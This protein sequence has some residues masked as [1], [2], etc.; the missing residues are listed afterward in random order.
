MP[1]AC[2]H[3]SN[4]TKKH[5]Q[6]YNITYPANQS[7]FLTWFLAFTKSFASFAISLLKS[8]VMNYHQHDGYF[9]LSWSVL[10][11]VNCSPQL[12][13]IQSMACFKA[14]DA[15]VQIRE[16]GI[17]TTYAFGKKSCHYH[18]ARCIQYHG[19]IMVSLPYSIHWIQVSL[20]IHL[21]E[22]WQIL[23]LT[24]SHSTIAWLPGYQTT[25]KKEQK[26]G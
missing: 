25:K 19:S 6:V 7:F 21:P 9:V 13:L 12:Y 14:C 16:H 20:Q 1:K 5:S 15:A 17:S 2:V 18:V 3:N 4:S 23:R 11:L 26:D 24:T 10:V 8:L 22:T